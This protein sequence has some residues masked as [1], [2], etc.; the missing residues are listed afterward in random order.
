M[1]GRPGLPRTSGGAQVRARVL[2][3]I[4]GRIGTY[5]GIP[6]VLGLLTGCSRIIPGMPGCIWV[7]PGGCPGASRI[8]WVHHIMLWIIDRKQ[9]ARLLPLEGAAG[10]N[11]GPIA[12][13]GGQ[14]RTDFVF[15]WSEGGQPPHRA[16]FC[17]VGRCLQRQ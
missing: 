3:H 2:P 5:P 16:C 13:E 1:P 15:V 9:A 4:F 10:P 14:L 11:P 8:S 12:S 6:G 7:Y 17:D